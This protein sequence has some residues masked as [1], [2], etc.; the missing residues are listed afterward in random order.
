MF[1]GVSGQFLGTHVEVLARTIQNRNGDADVLAG[2]FAIPLSMRHHDQLGL[3]QGIADTAMAQRYRQLAQEYDRLYERRFRYR[4][5]SRLWLETLS[6]PDIAEACRE[7]ARDCY[8][9]DQG[10][11]GFSSR[12]LHKLNFVG[13][14]YH[15]ALMSIRGGIQI[16]RD[17]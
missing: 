5:A 11:R 14:G 1:L 9:S 12:G 8:R 17:D 10:G 2:S 16:Y 6:L 4:Y 7:Y 13:S 15:H 3:G